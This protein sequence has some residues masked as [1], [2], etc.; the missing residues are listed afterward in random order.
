[1]DSNG[2]WWVYS[3]KPEKRGIRAAF[4]SYWSSDYEPS[5][6]EDCTFL[7]FNKDCEDWTQSLEERPQE[8]DY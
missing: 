4:N 8:G 2:E 5:C 6:F 3:R 7:D 1:M